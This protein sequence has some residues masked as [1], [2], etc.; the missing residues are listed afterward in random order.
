MRVPIH[1]RE[2]VPG[3]TIQIG[4]FST[5]PDDAERWRQSDRS[6]VVICADGQDQQVVAVLCPHGMGW[7]LHYQLMTASVDHPVDADDA[8]TATN[9][10]RN[11]MR[12]LFNGGREGTQLQSVGTEHPLPDAP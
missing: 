6:P 10:A 9:K 11:H 5:G 1:S 7:H 8:L 12:W 3:E 2:F 4:I